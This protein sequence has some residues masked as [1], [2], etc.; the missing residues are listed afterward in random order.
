MTRPARMRARKP[1]RADVSPSPSSPTT[2]APSLRHS[3]ESGNPETSGV[4]ARKALDSRVRGNDGWG[5][6][7]LSD[8]SLGRPV[9]SQRASSI[10]LFGREPK[11]WSAQEAELSA[12][13]HP[14]IPAKAGIQRPQ[15]FSR[16][17]PWIPAFAGMTAGGTRALRIVHR[18]G[19]H[20][21]IRCLV[22]RLASRVLRLASRVTRLGSHVRLQA[23]RITQAQSCFSGASTA[24][25][26]QRSCARTGLQRTTSLRG[27]VT[28]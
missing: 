8:S 5:D 12:L 24:R 10:V 11:R 26:S 16:E 22:S 6:A 7:G 3:R 23:S 25:R 21:R 14:V 27:K 15:A 28:R 13:P 19:R 1:A 2:R 9:F 18:F 17:K 4:L 20:S